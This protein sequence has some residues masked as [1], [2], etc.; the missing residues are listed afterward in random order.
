[1]K[2]TFEYR[3]IRKYRKAEHTIS[4][5]YK[6]SEFVCNILEDPVRVLVDKNGDGDFDDAGEGKIKGRTAI[7]KGRYRIK[8]YMSPRFRRLLPMLMDV[9]GFKYILIHAG[10]TV[11]DT[12]GCLLP[13]LN[14]AKGMV[15]DSRKYENI[16]VNEIKDAEAAGYEVYINITEP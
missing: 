12:D 11:E 14:R 15:L 7:P 9:P 10:N 4:E 6:G 5:L 8:M 16:L 13:G 1:M 3:M 2:K